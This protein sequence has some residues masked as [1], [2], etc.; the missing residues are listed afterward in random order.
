MMFY[1]HLVRIFMGIIILIFWCPQ[2]GVVRPDIDGNYEYFAD[3]NSLFYCLID[4]I[5]HDVRDLKI[6]E[7]HMTTAMCPAEEA[8]LCRRV[9]PLINKLQDREHYN[10]IF[11]DF[12]NE[13]RE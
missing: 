13:N 5:Y 1:G 8:E 3:A 4:E 10:K 7:E 9:I 12:L 11:R 6:V 2:F